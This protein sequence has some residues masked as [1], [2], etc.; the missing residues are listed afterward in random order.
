VH[1]KAGVGVRRDHELD[2]DFDIPELLGGVH[3]GGVSLGVHAR[4]HDAV[5]CPRQ[6]RQQGGIRG[7]APNHAFRDHPL[8]LFGGIDKL[9]AIEVPAVQ[10]G[11]PA[12]FN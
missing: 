11:F 8:A 3:V 5:A 4:V 7:T 2:I 1:E 6:C 12:A 9:P 10:Q